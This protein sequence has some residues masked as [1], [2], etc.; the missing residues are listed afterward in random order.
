M[1]QGNEV[2]KKQK[3]SEREKLLI[4]ERKIEEYAKNK[5]RVMQIRKIRDDQRKAEK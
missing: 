4:E 2:I 3:E 1:I 5:E